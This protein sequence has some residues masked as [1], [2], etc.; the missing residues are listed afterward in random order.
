MDTWNSPDL[1][2]C[3]YLIAQSWLISWLLVKDNFKGSYTL[4]INERFCKRSYQCKIQKMLFLGFQYMRRILLY[5]FLLFFLLPSCSNR[6][7]TKVVK[8]KYHH[9]AYDRKKDKRTKRTKP[10]KVQN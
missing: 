6:N 5:A 3:R 10:M 8:P 4:K 7:N 2:I 1:L 9:R